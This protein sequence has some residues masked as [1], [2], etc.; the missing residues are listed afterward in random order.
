M[1]PA[2]ASDIS[3]QYRSI[4][5][6]RVHAGGGGQKYILHVHLRLFV[7]LNLLVDVKKS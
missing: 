2:S 1:P 7:V 5:V 4:L 3:V 6:P